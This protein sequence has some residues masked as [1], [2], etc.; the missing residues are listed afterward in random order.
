MDRFKRTILVGSITF[1]FLMGISMGF[2]LLGCRASL[3]CGAFCET[4]GNCTDK[5]GELVEVCE[6]KS[7]YVYCRC[8]DVQAK[9]WCDGY[10]GWQHPVDTYDDPMYD[11]NFFFDL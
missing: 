9:F 10:Q 1:L 3:P 2:D 11:P 8:G 7:D 4:F 5:T 6:A